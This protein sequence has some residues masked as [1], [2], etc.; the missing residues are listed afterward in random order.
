MRISAGVVSSAANDVLDASSQLRT[1]WQSAG[2]ALHSMP[3]R[4]AGDTA[5]GSRLVT[6]AL[7]CVTAADDALVILSDVLESASDSLFRCSVDFIDTDEE[8]AESMRIR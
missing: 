6:G 1:G 8:T 3:T 2:P 5:G 4:A 7:D